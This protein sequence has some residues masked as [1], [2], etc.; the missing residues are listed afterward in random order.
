[1]TV[2]EV[3]P[4]VENLFFLSC[5][6]VSFA[7]EWLLRDFWN[8][9]DLQDCS[10]VTIL[11]IV[12]MLEVKCWYLGMQAFFLQN[13]ADKTRYIHTLSLLEKDGRDVAVMRKIEKL[14]N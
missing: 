10:C 12:E 9:Y 3:F 7:V 6:K 13:P 5:S 8:V 2:A 1:M 14:H 4:K 11:V